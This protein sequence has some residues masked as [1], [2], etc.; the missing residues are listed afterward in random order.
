MTRVRLIHW[1][2]AEAEERAA[3][4]EAL[5]YQVDAAVPR[6]PATIRE[7]AADPPAAVVIDLARLPS[8]GRDVAVNLR[9]Q[10]GSRRVP[11]LFVGGDPAKVPA[12]RDLLPDAVY[13]TW[14]EIGAALPEAIAAPPANP[15]VPASAFAA[16]AGRPLLGKLG[17]KGGTHLALLG[18]PAGFMDTLGALPEGVS[19]GNEID[20]AT[21]LAMWF[22]RSYAELQAGIEGVAAQVRRTSLWIAWPKKGSPLAA[23]LGEPL[24]RKAG[25]A[26]GLVD[27]KI[28]SIDDTWSALLFRRRK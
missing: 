17:I 10:A 23:D 26:T 22:V 19:V 14:E 6:G 4:L 21:D 7:L 11:L 25:R 15:V 16:Y 27:F 18:A 28:C 13:S 1:N 12:I 2:A 8:Q 24:V 5:G 3:R 9:L 20:A